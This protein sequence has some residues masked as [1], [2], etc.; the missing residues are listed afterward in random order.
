MGKEEC[1]TEVNARREFRRRVDEQ[2]S[3]Y[4]D[5][6][7]FSNALT[8]QKQFIGVKKIDRQNAKLIF[9]DNKILLLIIVIIR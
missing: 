6:C 3:K 7:N 1:V 4:F 8:R 5:G 9:R 2:K